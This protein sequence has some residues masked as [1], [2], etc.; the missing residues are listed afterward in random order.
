METF[1]EIKSP[2]DY[3]LWTQTEVW[4]LD[5]VWSVD[6]GHNMKYINCTQFIVF[7]FDT[8][9]NIAIRYSIDEGI[10]HPVVKL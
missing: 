10:T 2:P 1:I 5:T 7:V 9:S 8:I 3:S 4:V 6:T